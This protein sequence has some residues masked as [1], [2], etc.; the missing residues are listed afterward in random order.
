MIGLLI[1]DLSE[2]KLLQFALNRIPMIQLSMLNYV[3]K[4]I[5]PDILAKERIMIVETYDKELNLMT[6][7]SIQELERAKEESS[8]LWEKDTIDEVIRRKQDPNYMRGEE[9]TG[10]RNR[11]IKFNV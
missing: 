2:L 4:H 10:K 3:F 11:L 7:W 5:R 9:P 6:A 1:R 8:N